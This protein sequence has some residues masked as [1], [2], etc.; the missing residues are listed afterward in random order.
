M[1]S[2]CHCCCCCLAGAKSSGPPIKEQILHPVA[3]QGAGGFRAGGQAG[4]GTSQGGMRQRSQVAGSRS[5]RRW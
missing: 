1:Q 4:A 2:P 3:P 5:S